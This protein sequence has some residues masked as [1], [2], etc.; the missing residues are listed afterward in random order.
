LQPA[1][2]SDNEK[3]SL[4][5]LTGSDCVKLVNKYSNKTVSVR[6]GSDKPGTDLIEW[7]D[8]KAGETYDKKADDTWKIEKF[9]ENFIIVNEV[10]GQC[11]SEQ[12]GPD[13]KAVQEP[14]KGSDDQLW[15]IER[16][17]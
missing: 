13:R 14:W 4:N 10:S 3:W 15:R 5:H 1:S 6:A 8:W 16:A 12:S 2:H 17:D 7:F 9:G 11:L